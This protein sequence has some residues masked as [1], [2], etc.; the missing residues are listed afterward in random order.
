MTTR[1]LTIHI[2]AAGVG[3]LAALSQQVTMVKSATNLPYAVVWQAFEP[4]Q[5]SLVTWDLDFRVYES[6]TVLDLTAVLR[7]GATAPA[8]GGNR[9]TFSGGEFDTGTSNPPAT[10]FGIANNDANIVVN[11]VAMFTGGLIQTAIVNGGST[12]NPLDAQA[13]GYGE[14]AFTTVTDSVLV[15]PASGVTNGTLLA[16]SWLGAGHADIVDFDVV[17]GEPLHVD[18]TTTTQLAIRYNDL[19]N[20]FVLA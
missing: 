16:W 7:V 17:V 19:T 4:V 20:S 12:A 13:I 6:T 1:Q 14:Q 15:F 8:A 9:Y 10:Q 3:A 18:L 5:D 2:D 11:G